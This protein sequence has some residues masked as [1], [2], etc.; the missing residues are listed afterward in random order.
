MPWSIVSFFYTKNPFYPVFSNYGPSGL[1]IWSLNPLVIIKNVFSAFLLS[2]D[3]INPVYIIA[4]PLLFILWNRLKKHLAIIIYVFSSVV[5]WYLAT[6][7]GVWHATDQAGGSRFLTPYLPGITLLAVIVLSKVKTKRTRNIFI[8]TIV[9][10]SMSAVF[11]RFFAS[12]K[13]VPVVLGLQSKQEFLMQKLNFDFGDFYDEN[14]EIK[15]I[16]KNDKVLVIGIHN[17]YYADFKFTLPE[18]RDSKEAKYVLIRNGEM[19]SGF[20]KEIYQNTKTHV[21]LYKL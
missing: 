8:I 12:L 15:Q 10:I 9:L 1:E 18:W 5:M 21:K 11:Y 13:Y 19:E 20:D 2:P 16:V 3:P 4:L 14:G 6:Y 7:I 17:L